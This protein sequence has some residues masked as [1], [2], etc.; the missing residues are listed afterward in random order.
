MASSVDPGLS[1]QS[2][3]QDGG[4][5][6]NGQQ[7]VV[8]EHCGASRSSKSPNSV[9]SPNGDDDGNAGPPRDARVRHQAPSSPAD[10]YHIALVYEGMRI[11]I[12][13]YQDMPVN[14]LM[15]QA[16]EN[17]QL[18]SDCIVLVLF[19]LHPRTL[20]RDSL[21]SDPPPVHEGA[22]VMVFFVRTQATAYTGGNVPSPQGQVR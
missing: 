7:T 14:D 9:P 4:H 10:L 11:Q 19:G 12:Q 21:I 3:W 16:G 6:H 20:S 18:D 13:V 17:F 2:Q 1:P 22:T 5:T 8:L 15:R